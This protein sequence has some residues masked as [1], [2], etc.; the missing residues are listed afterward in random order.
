MQAVSGNII[1]KCEPRITLNYKDAEGIEQ[2]I[3]WNAKDIKSFNYKQGADPLNRTLPFIEATWT[4]LYYGDLDEENEPVKYN[5]VGQFGLVTIEFVQDLTVGLNQWKSLYNQGVKWSDLLTTTWKSVLRNKQQEIVEMPKLFLSAKPE[6]KDNIIAWKAVDLLSLM[7]SVQNKVIG[8]NEWSLNPQGFS[9]FYKNLISNIMLD[10]RAQFLKSPYVLNAITNTVDELVNGDT[11]SFIEFKKPF[12]MSGTTRDCILNI[13]ASV[14]YRLKFEENKISIT[15]YLTNKT[16]KI[17]FTKRN[18]K[19]YPILTKNPSVSSYQYKK[20]FFSSVEDKK[21]TCFPTVEIKDGIRLM[22]WNFD[23]MGRLPEIESAESDGIS[24]NNYYAVTYWITMGG[25]TPTIDVIPL[26]YESR[27]MIDSFSVQGEAFIEDNKINVYDRSGDDAFISNREGL[28]KAY[29]K[30]NAC[31]ME[32]EAFPNLAFE[33][34]DVVG[35]ETNL[36]S[37]GKSVIKNA[38]IVEIELNYNGALTEKIKAH[39]VIDFDY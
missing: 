14:G 9:I 18:L 17:A 24:N 34:S 33:V 38:V 36:K 30:D 5:N 25:P 39:E 3:V 12:L 27:D 37:Q 31:S 15:E 4:E 21:Y 28:I 20:Y 6:I 10:E 7:T 32:F 11:L 23:G 19:K 2:T 16:E 35:V 29:F 22:Y 8:Y 26:N 13:M 1:P